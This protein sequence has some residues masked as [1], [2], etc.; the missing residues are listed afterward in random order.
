MYSAGCFTPRLPGGF[1][2]SNI[3]ASE[4]NCCFP[5]VFSSRCLADFSRRLRTILYELLLRMCSGKLA[6]TRKASSSFL[7]LLLR[8]EY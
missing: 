2:V 7:C 6:H 8:S 1:V 5:L 4:S 3:E